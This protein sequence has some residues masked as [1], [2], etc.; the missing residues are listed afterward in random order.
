[1]IPVVHY[2]TVSILQ[3]CFG[4]NEIKIEPTDETVE[5]EE[6]F[7]HDE[8]YYA[9]AEVSYMY[10]HFIKI[11]KWRPKRSLDDFVLVIVL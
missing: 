2:P 11:P 1:M 9:S 8:N 3:S 10:I 4:L 6:K 5:V 7:F